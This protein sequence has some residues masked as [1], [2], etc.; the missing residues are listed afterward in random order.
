MTSSDAVNQPAAPDTRVA[1]PLGVLVPLIHEDLKQGRAAAERAGLPY[2]RAAGEKMLEAKPQLPHGEFKAWIARHFRVSYRQAWQYMKLA[3]AAGGEK[4]AAAN[5]STLSDFRRR[6]SD[7]KYNRR[8]SWRA[9]LDTATA[10]LLRDAMAGAEEREAQ[11]VLA[12]KVINIGYRALARELHPDKGGSRDA[13]AR[14]N[15]A[16]DR[17]K[18]CV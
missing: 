15:A 11:R 16:R 9:G 14:L 18:Q 10:N 12:L 7:P 4:F 2:Y 1:R 6:T 17:L 5:F 13:M 8:A 3:E